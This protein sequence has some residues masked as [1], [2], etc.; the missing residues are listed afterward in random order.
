MRTATPY[1]LMS[2]D[3]EGNRRVA[4]TSTYEESKSICTD[5][6]RSKHTDIVFTYWHPTKKQ[7]VK[8]G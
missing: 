3:N 8:R 7:Y 5:W 6:I 4:F 2:K 1:K